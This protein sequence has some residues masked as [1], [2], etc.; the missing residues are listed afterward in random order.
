[1]S[2]GRVPYEILMKDGE[3]I[4]AFVRQ[5]DLNGKRYDIPIELD[6]PWLRPSER[7]RELVLKDIDE[8]EPEMA[9]LRNTRLKKGWESHGGVQIATS[10]GMQW[11]LR[12]EKV[13][14]DRA[15]EMAVGSIVEGVPMDS[16]GQLLLENNHQEVMSPGFLRSWGVHIAVGGV[17]ILGAGL[18]A[19]W[20][21]F[22]KDWASL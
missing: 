15:D 10:Q 11:V 20:G 7:E 16:A 9:A 17:S 5:S 2:S 18:L 6:A 3:R 21:F 13:L 14:A 4:F 1:M 12:S 22:R 8:Y 19:W